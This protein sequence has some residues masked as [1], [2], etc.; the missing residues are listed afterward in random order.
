MAKGLTMA[1]RVMSGLKSIT[2]CAFSGAVQVA[3]VRLRN[4]LQPSI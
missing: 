3:G 1:S 2:H 4:M